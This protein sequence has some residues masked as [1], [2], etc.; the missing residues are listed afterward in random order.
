MW[1]IGITSRLKDTM[2]RH[3]VFSVSVKNGLYRSAIWNISQKQLEKLDSWKFRHLKKILGI[4]WQDYCSYVALIERI[5][6]L[7]IDIDT[8]EATIRRFQ[9]N[10]LGHVLRM[11]ETRHPI[12]MLH[13]EIA[14]GKRSA[15]GQ[16][17]TYRQCIKNTLKIFSI[18]VG[19]EF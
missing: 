7:D 11:K 15:G 4:K 12:I 9:L 3:R 10:Y 17:L 2:S 16:E 18:N 8:M 19:K 14:L 5:R 1:D 6:S 13:A